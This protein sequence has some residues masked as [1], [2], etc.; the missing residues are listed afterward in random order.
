MEKSI[1]SDQIN[2][3]RLDLAN[4]PGS[5]ALAKATANVGP[6]AASHGQF[7]DTTQPAAFSDE[8]DTGAVT[9]QKRSGRCW[10]FSQLNT[11]RHFT[12]EKFGIKD[13]E[14]SQNYLSFYDR[15]EKANLFLEHVIATAREPL[16]NRSLSIYLAGPDTDGGYYENAAGLVEKY[17]LVP[18]SVMP[19]TY[20]SENTS[21]ISATL[22]LK[23]RRSAVQLRQQAADG[24]GDDA[25]RD[26]KD[27]ILSDIYRI[28]AYGFGTP[29]T[30]FDFEYRDKDKKFHAD[31]N[32]TP[33]SFFKKYVGWDLDDYV[34]VLSTTEPGKEYY[35]SYGLPLEDTVVGGRPIKM[36]NVP[37]N[38][39]EQLAIK[40]IQSGETVWFG[41]DVLAD[42]DRNSG[43]LHGGLFDLNHLF[44]ADFTLDQ[45]N[46]FAT[47]Q[48]M[49]SHAMTLTGVDLVDGQ[50]RKWKVENSWGKDR[51]RDGYFTADEAWFQD[52]V[53]QVVIK[54][55]LLPQDILDAY[56][57]EAVKLPA[58][59]R[60][61]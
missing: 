33:M 42:M 22:N 43:T 58:W 20:N 44:N 38:V 32:L 31:R 50:P 1:T 10:L 21:E 27:A 47:G 15:L 35:Q 41:N 56:A 19:E 39:L 48:A 57:K 7:E 17:G 40:Q 12:S 13:L 36:V 2:Q 16:T 25:L 60:L 51:G 49:V 18:K 61:N 4:T 54:K 6:Y 46:R 29:P 5:A 55:S 53:Y 28:L 23:L 8:I 3:Y 11:M 24:A 59:D 34:T 9:N 30:T 26:G 45:G 14:F 37:Q 52:Y